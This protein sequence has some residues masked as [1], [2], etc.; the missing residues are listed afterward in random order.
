MAQLLKPE[1]LDFEIKPENSIKIQPIAAGE[2]GVQFQPVTVEFQTVA[3]RENG[4]DFQP[5]LIE[6]PENELKNCGPRPKAMT[7]FT[8]Q[9]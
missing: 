9:W 2:N 1:I 3:T 4:V 7:T 8:N 5:T 6:T